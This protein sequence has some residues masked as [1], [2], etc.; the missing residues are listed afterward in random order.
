MTK[1]R[2][3][4]LI[5]LLI[6][7]AVIGVLAAVAY[8]AYTNQVERGRRSEGKAVL[9]KA[10]QQMERYY[11]INNCYPSATAACGNA[12]ASAAALT[13]AGILAFS[14][15]NAATSWYTVSVTVNPQDFTL[16]ATPVAARGFVDLKCGNL[17]LSN[18]GAKAMSGTDTLANCW[19]R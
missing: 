14:A 18:T 3:M 15:D 17:T 16:T 11:T 9:L 19:S 7:V 4:T 6:V 12:A 5:E 13:A 8:P 2:G 10:A 1:Q